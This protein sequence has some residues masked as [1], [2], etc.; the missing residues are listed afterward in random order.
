MGCCASTASGTGEESAL[1]LR[2]LEASAFSVFLPDAKLAEFAVYFELQT[3]PKGRV[4]WF[5]VYTVVR[6]GILYEEGDYADTLY[7]L[8]DGEVELHHGKSKSDL[9]S[10]KGSAH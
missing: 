10:K 9:K 8:G 2:I 3:I 1:R 6:A 4:F 7:V 5:C